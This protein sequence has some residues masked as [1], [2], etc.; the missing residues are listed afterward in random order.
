MVTHLVP[1]VQ[2]QETCYLAGGRPHDW[3]TQTW[4]KKKKKIKMNYA[5]SKI[6]PGRA[7]ADTNV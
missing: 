6:L 1:L 7:R 4:A 5:G 2:T 3:P